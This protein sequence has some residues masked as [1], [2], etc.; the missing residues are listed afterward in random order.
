MSVEVQV[1]AG[2]PC[3][4]SCAKPA[5]PLS[6]AATQLLNTLHTHVRSF[7]TAMPFPTFSSQ[8]PDLARRESLNLL[9][10]RRIQADRTR[11]KHLIKESI[12]Q[13]LNQLPRL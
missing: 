1:L 9:I 12:A 8:R 6:H 10:R 4:I 7:P 3:K 5:F 11:G 13:L 2:P